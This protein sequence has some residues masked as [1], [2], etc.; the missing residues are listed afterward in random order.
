MEYNKIK[1]TILYLVGAAEV[2]DYDTMREILSED[3]MNF[4]TRNSEIEKIIGRENYIDVI[5]NMNFAGANLKMDVV[6]VH[7]I[8]AIQAC[9]CL[10]Y[11][12]IIQ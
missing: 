8:N 11:R 12:P 7:V 6:S 5:K 3:M 10:R 4:E 9:L 2:G 1:N